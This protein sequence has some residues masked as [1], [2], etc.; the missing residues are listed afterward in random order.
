MIRALLSQMSSLH[1]RTLARFHRSEQPKAD[2]AERRERWNRVIADH[3]KPPEHHE[4]TAPS[5]RGGTG[6]DGG[7]RV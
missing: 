2:A 4:R 6:S 1:R 7:T 5:F 3:Q